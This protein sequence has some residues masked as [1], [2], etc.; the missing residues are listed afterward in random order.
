MGKE[1]ADELYDQFGSTIEGLQRTVWKDFSNEKV[2]ERLEDFYR[3]VYENVDPTSLL[4]SDMDARSGSTGYSHA[5]TQERKLARQ[6]LK[7][8]PHSIAFASNS[9]SW[10]V[11]NVLRALGLEKLSKSCDVFT[12]D[13][14]STYPTKHQPEEFFSI[15]NDDENDKSGLSQY[16]SISFLD[17]SLHNLN[18][19]KEA[20]PLHV[21]KVHHINRKREIDEKKKASSIDH[22]EENL[23]QA[24]LQDFGLIEPTFR[25]SQTRYL[26]SKNK[27][28]RRS[29]HLKTWNKVI[30][31]LKKILLDIGCEETTGL[32]NDN[33]D[34][35]IEDLGAG[36]LSM[37]DLLLHGDS[38][39][40]L[41]A[42]ISTS[43]SFSDDS[44]SKTV[45][46]TAYES[47]QELY[48]ASHE[49]LL[50]WGFDVIE[51]KVCNEDRETDII[52]Y[53][54][55]HHGLDLRVKLILRDFANVNREE[56]LEKQKRTPNLIIGCCFADL[57]DP[58]QLVPDLL[59]SFGLLGTKASSR[60]LIYFPITF[61]GT[62]QFIPPHPFEFQ[63]N[64]RTVPSDTVGFQSYSQALETVLGHNLDPGLLQDVLEDHGAKLVDFGDSDWVIDPKRDSYLYETMLYFFGSTGGPQLLKGGWDAAEW[65]Q[66][67]RNN[68]PIIQVSNRDLL[69]CMEPNKIV[70]DED[71]NEQLDE[72]KNMAEIL[73]TAPSQV[74]SVERNYPDQLGPRQVVGKHNTGFE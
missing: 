15:D 16:R 39:L 27:V 51:K 19:V 8:C 71:S 46:Y 53:Q 37:L 50:S 34:L 6:L 42:L 9:P 45:H 69:F 5:S 47:N 36:L 66:R 31:E 1:K 12:P 26:E 72:E 44:I 24:L 59:R 52:D 61:T 64:K 38:E 11:S 55:K 10:H 40:G 48:E 43:D 33:S 62:T 35:W 2:E 41:S 70:D 73:F 57:I 63:S 22:G 58:N 56:L 23:V 20:F 68:Q 74:T 49:R 14:L 17:D 29:L 7:S 25:L 65:I 28:D 60:T 3:T 54:K 30:D 18:R 32:A 13:R 21:D 67:A 4:L